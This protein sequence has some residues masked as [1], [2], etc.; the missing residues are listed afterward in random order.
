MDA[1]ATDWMGL[2][3]GK[4]QMSCPIDFLSVRLSRYAI[5]TLLLAMDILSVFFLVSKSTLP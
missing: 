3:I 2:A 1:R 5:S 4:S